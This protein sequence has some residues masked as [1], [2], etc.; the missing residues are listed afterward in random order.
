[1]NEQNNPILEVKNLRVSYHT[2]AG[3]VKAVRGV[4]FSLE[5]GQAL[6]IVGESGCGKSVTAKSIMGLIKA[7]QGEIKENSEILYHGE[8]ILKYNK[9][10]WQHYKGG[11]C[12]IIFQDALASLNPTM[13]VGKQIM[14]NLMGHKNMTKQE[15]AKEAVEMLR[16]VGIPEPEK[17]VRQYPHEFSGGMRQRVMIAIAFACDPKIL[18][19]DEP[20]TALDV[21][22][23]GQILDIIKNLQK[24]NQTSVIMITHDLGVVANIAQKIAVMYS[25]IIVESGTCEDIFYRPRH[26]YT[27][28][29]IRSVPRL[30]LKNKQEL[31]TIPGTPPD[32]LNPPVGCPFCT[33]CSYCMPICKEEMPEVTEFGG[34]HKA[35]CWLHHP[36][37]PKVEMPNLD[38]I[39]QV[40]K[41]KNNGK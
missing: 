6:A 34:E 37:A 4:Q 30:D 39:N 3:E 7:P 28:A 36:M 17:R 2:Y 18:I 26:P 32:L 41:D 11:E 5:K 40:R 8:N 38:F 31:A 20:T 24:K 9:K 12:A 10:Q 25:G 29:L 14:E 16:M 27:W 19:C 21:T 35:A 23:Q 22:I 13:R 15:A 33:R 1:M